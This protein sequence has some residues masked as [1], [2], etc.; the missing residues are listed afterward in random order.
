MNAPALE[1]LKTDEFHFSIGFHHSPGALRRKLLISP[2][3]RRL[4]GALRF[5]AITERMISDFVSSVMSEFCKGHRLPNDLALAAL[6]IVLE[7]RPTDFAEEYLHDLARL[8][9]AELSTSINV[10]RECLKN[11]CSVPKHQAKSFTFP[12]TKDNLPVAHWVQ[13]RLRPRVLVTPRFV[14]RYPACLET[15]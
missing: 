6:A 10:A 9:L 14:S 3:V 15:A 5:G 13:S 12:S 1:R 7:L 11:R 2:D 8:K 4:A